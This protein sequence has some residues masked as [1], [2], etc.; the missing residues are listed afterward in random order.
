MIGGILYADVMYNGNLI[1]LQLKP[2]IGVSYTIRN[3][4][5]EP[6]EIYEPKEIEFSNVKISY[7]HNNYSL[8][9]FLSR[10]R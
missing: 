6:E 1:Q 5:F 3:G 7:F 8:L 2:E 4:Q 9:A 10:H